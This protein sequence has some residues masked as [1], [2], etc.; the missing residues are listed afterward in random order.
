MRDLLRS[1]NARLY[2]TGQV[3]SLFGDSSMFLAMGIWVK[4]L[5]GSNSAAGLVFFAY[6]LP[7]LFSPVFGVLVDRFRRRPL[8]IFTNFALGFVVLLLLFVHGRDTVWIIYLV[9]ILYGLSY[10]IIGSAGPALLSTMLPDELLGYGNGALSTVQE[11]LRL[12]GP[13]AGAGLFVAVGGGW[14]AVIDSATFFI[15]VVCLL[16]IKVDEPRLLPRESHWFDEAAA[17]ARHIFRSAILRQVTIATTI[18]VFVVGF[19]DTVMFAI[20]SQGLHRPT[21]FLGI[22]LAMQGVGGLLGGLSAAAV[23]RRVGEGILCGIGLGIVAVTCVALVSSS[24][25]LVLVAFSL[26]GMGTPWI[27]VSITT[28]YQR[29]TPP[30]LHGRTFAALNLL[31]GLPQTASIAVG[32]ALIAVVNYRYT[33]LSVAAMVAIGAVYLL[34]RPE[35][36]K[37][38]PREQNERDQAV[39]KE[40]SFAEP[41]R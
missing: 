17:G 39:P 18:A 8:L 25:P 36:W 29:L 23:M 14:I 9:M 2:L 40:T 16:L 34:T 3:V 22:M 32:A 12:V 7:Q 15:A 35:Q 26:L 21:A 10:N 24:L 27:V 31:L 37:R 28:L 19:M 1:R 30:N 4:M 41:N 11:G 20:V 5:T 6:G 38:R 33:V 13:I